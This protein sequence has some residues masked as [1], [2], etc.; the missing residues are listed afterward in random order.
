MAAGRDKGLRSERDGTVEA[1]DV[2]KE[3]EKK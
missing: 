3:L 1:L 2:T